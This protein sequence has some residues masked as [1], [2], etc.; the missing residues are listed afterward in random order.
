MKVFEYA[1]E[2]VCRMSLS[3]SKGFTYK[4]LSS[5]T[6]VIGEIMYMGVSVRGMHTDDTFSQKVSTVRI[7]KWRM[8]AKHSEYTIHSLAKYGIY[9]VT[10]LALL[11]NS[12]TSK[13]IF[14]VLE[15]AELPKIAVSRRTL[16]AL[17]I[18]SLCSLCQLRTAIYCGPTCTEPTLR[19]LCKRCANES[20]VT[21]RSLIRDWALASDD[22]RRISRLSVRFYSMHGDYFF[23]WIPKQQVCREMNV[24][25]WELF[26]GLTGTRRR[27]SLNLRKSMARRLADP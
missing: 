23:T 6:G 19:Q 1:S 2:V 15:D 13:S 9:T 17:R 5:L 14:L 7:S 27:K 4:I 18:S 12:P 24:L 11:R 10:F 8:V 21:E 26:I 25:S 16:L 22:S 20:L 3:L